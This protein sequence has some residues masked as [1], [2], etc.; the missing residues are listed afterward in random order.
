MFWDEI[1][2]PLRGECRIVSNTGV[3]IVPMREPSD[4]D[5]EGISDAFPF[6]AKPMVKKKIPFEHPGG[7]LELREIEVEEDDPEVIKAWESAREDIEEMRWLAL[8]DASIEKDT[9]VKP[10]GE[11]IRE[12]VEFLRKM[13]KFVRV[14]LINAARELI[15]NRLSERYDEAKKE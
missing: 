4:E 15:D 13:P 5:T 6:P 12:R 3:K 2:E 7:K 10:P 9:Q 14:K 11:T 8:V 1:R